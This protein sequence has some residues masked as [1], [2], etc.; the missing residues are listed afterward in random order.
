MMSTV[1]KVTLA[2]MQLLG[3]QLHLNVLFFAEIYRR[4]DLL[5]D[6]DRHTHRTFTGHSSEAWLA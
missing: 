4:G 2:H 6:L 5:G 1:T 3:K